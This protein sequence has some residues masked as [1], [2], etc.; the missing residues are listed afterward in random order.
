[1][2]VT[3][4]QALGLTRGGSVDQRILPSHSLTAM[5][6]VVTKFREWTTVSLFVNFFVILSSLLAAH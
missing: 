4:V 2:M 6:A 3:L 1:M 5:S